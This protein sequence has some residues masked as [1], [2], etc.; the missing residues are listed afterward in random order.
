MLAWE[1]NLKDDLG[2]I[3]IPPTPAAVTTTSDQVI[4]RRVIFEDI[5][6]KN[7]DTRALRDAEGKIIFLYSF[8]DKNTIVIA[9]NADTLQKITERLL[10]GKLIQ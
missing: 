1:N 4:N 10:A 2:P 6:V 8:P 9:T 5:V 3:F 7:R